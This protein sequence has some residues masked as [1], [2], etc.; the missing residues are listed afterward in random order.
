MRKFTLLFCLL[1]LLSSINLQAQTNKKWVLVSVDKKD[2]VYIYRK[3]IVTRQGTIKA[4]T[5]VIPLEASKEY[6]IFSE[7]K[8][9]TEYD[10]HKSQFRFVNIIHYYLDGTTQVYDELSEWREIPPDSLSE[11]LLETV[12]KK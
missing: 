12:C 2:R 11:I 8:M 10:C 3:K 7:R 1:L 5:K 4:W 9:L 6:S